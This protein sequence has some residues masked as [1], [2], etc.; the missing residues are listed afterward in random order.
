VAVAS[1]FGHWVDTIASAA[2]IG[3]G[4]WIQKIATEHGEVERH[5]CE[6]A[7]EIPEPH[8][9]AVTLRMDHEGHA[10]AYSVLVFW[11]WPVLQHRKSIT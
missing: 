9:F 2:L 3:F 11:I 4:A 8:Q 1:R 6:S 10:H 7:E 5:Y